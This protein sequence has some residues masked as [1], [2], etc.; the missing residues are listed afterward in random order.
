MVLLRPAPDSEFLI[1]DNPV[2]THIWTSGE[3]RTASRIGWDAADEIVMPFAPDLAVSLVRD[4]ETRAVT[5][6][7]VTNETAS[8][9]RVARL[10]GRQVNSARDYVFHRPGYKVPSHFTNL[11]NTSTPKQRAEP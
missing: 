5:G 6:M 10:N 3:T 11:R 9:E 8:I 1:G 4:A 7:P 2:T